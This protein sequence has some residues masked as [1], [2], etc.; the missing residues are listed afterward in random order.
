MIR[1][2]G[3]SGFDVVGLLVIAAVCLVLTRYVMG[4]KKP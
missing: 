3:I 4:R 2:Y 1:G